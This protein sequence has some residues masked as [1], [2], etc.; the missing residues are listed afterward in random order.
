MRSRLGSGYSG[1]TWE[2]NMNLTLKCDQEVDGRWI[3]EVPEL[4]GVLAYGSLSA[5]ALAKAEVVALR[6]IADRLENGESEPIS[7]R[8]SLP[9]SA[10]VIGRQP[11]P[12]KY[13]RPCSPLGRELSVSRDRTRRWSI[14]IIR[15]MSSHSMM[16]MRLAPGCCLES[17]STPASNQMIC[18]AGGRS[19]NN[20]IHLSRHLKSIDA[21]EQTDVVLFA[22]W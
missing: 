17:L 16:A 3:A 22:A 11:K 6:V 8:F 14:Q 19:A 21:M 18:D 4:P 10:R 2:A 1:I 9:L 5:D 20:A 12:R 7:I 13:W 15:I